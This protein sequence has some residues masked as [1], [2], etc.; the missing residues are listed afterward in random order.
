MKAETATH[1]VMRHPGL[2]RVNA[3]CST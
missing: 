3:L 2:E 1:V